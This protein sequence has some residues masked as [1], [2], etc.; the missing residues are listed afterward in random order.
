MIDRPNVFFAVITVARQIDGEYVFVKTDKAYK[1][2]K[3]AD[4]ALSKLKAEYID[5]ENRPIPQEIS[6]PQGKAICHL[7]VGA[8]EIII[9]EEED[10]NAT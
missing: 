4:K 7:E 10:G 9:D 6:T 2:A 3:K 1:S 5:E 8:F